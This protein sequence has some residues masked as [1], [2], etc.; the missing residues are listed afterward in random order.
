MNRLG[1]KNV[2]AYY[3]QLVVNKEVHVKAVDGV[4]LSIGKNEVLGVVGESGC[5]KSTLAKVMM[6]NIIPPLE[7]IKGEVTLITRNN[8]VLN[9]EKIPREE[10]KSKVWGKHIAMI[11]QDA[12]SALMPTLKIK[13]I[14][15]D[16][17]RAH[18]PS[19]GINEVIEKLENRLKELGLPEYVIHRYPFELSGGM[20]QRTVIATAT[21]LNPEVIIVDEPTSALDVV[22]Q[23]I[24]LNTLMDLV[25][26]E[27]V[28]SMIFIS[29]DI[30]IVRQIA[31]KIAVM[32]AGKIVEVADTDDIIFRSK[33]PYTQGLVESVTTLEPEMRKR[34]IRYI[35]GQP[36]NL[37]NPPPGCRF[38]NRCKYSMDI[39]QREE[40]PIT[41]VKK[42]HSVF[43]W[44]YVKR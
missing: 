30:A 15:F 1:L 24:V 37:I 27:I 22:T 11:P 20:A 33:H 8:E 21:L 9:L 2:V 41:E 32:Y 5:G 16:V 18:V 3:R 14:A 23:R 31:S 38:S 10:L 40:P 34:G 25:K 39:C 4:S 44:L 17:V 7:F 28:E 19:V 13:R 12:M 6:M 43:C 42:G 26:K 29:H 36:P 35:P